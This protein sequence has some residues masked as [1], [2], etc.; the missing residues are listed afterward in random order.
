MQTIAPPQ[1]VQKPQA[2]PADP[3]L[4][5]F[6]EKAIAQVKVAMQRE[7]ALGHGLRVGV[8]GG[9][10]SGWEYQMA[11]AERPVPGDVVLEFGGV[12]VF[13]DQASQPF[14]RGVT[15]DYVSGLHGAGFKFLN[16]NA[17]R[18]CGCGSSFSV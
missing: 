14:L 1:C 9:G 5:H 6:T 11:L 8:R 18:T 13:V 10:C 3:E 12:R 16:P 2:E 15:I 7:G 17:S 4:L